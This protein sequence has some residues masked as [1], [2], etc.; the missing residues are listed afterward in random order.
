M[1]R[2]YLSNITK[3]QKKAGRDKAKAQRASRIK[4]AIQNGANV[5]YITCKIKQEEYETIIRLDNEKCIIDTTKPSDITKCI[6][7]GYKIIGLTFG[8]DNN[9]LYGA[10]FEGNL[11]S[12]TI[13]SMI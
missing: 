2:G 10:I 13:R 5:D 8:K 4:E 12:I 3:E 9:V 11:N 6:K 1:A 7:L